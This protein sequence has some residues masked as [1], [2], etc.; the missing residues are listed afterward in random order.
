MLSD[1]ALLYVRVED[2]EK[3]YN[4]TVKDG[5]PYTGPVLRAKRSKA[6][7]FLID[8]RAL[9]RALPIIIPAGYGRKDYL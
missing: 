9:F 1:N 6:G 5:G 2:N 7:L 8:G 4:Y 3:R